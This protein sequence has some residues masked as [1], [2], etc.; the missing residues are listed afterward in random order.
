MILRYLILIFSPAL[1]LAQE[2][3]GTIIYEEVTQTAY[4]MKKAGIDASRFKGNMP[5]ER[6]N[7]KKLTFTSEASLYEHYENLEAPPEQ[8]TYTRR[9]GSTVT[10]TRGGMRRGQSTV[11]RNIPSK[12]T[13]DSR[14]FFDKKFLI[15]GEDIKSWKIV[16]E[17]REI[18]GYLCQRAEWQ[19]DS[20]TLVVAWFTMQIPVASG[21][22]IYAG[23]PGMVLKVS[24]N[25]GEQVITA[26]KIEFVEKLKTPI[27]APSKGKEVTLEEYKV[28]VR[29]KMQEMREM[30][31]ANGGG[32]GRRF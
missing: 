8:I 19:K 5:N 24:I 32:G 11:Y 1:V 14:D 9:D 13:I 17:Q 22:E 27:S 6:K 26:N 10:R 20:A 21:P 3:T 23:L 2:N 4:A 29:D 16:M 7:Q 30:R 31:R 15:T 12:S 25:H 18:L 28:I